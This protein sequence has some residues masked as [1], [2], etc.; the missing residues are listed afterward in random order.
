MSLRFEMGIGVTST[1]GYTVPE[2][3]RDLQTREKPDSFK[4]PVLK[5]KRNENPS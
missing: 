1:Y 2:K 5:V 3:P 4:K